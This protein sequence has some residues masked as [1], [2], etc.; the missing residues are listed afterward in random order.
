MRPPAFE[1]GGL[2]R[3]SGGRAA[4]V[5][6]EQAEAAVAVGEGWHTWGGGGALVFTTVPLQ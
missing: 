6:L 4:S 1:G 3:K 5:P 2:G